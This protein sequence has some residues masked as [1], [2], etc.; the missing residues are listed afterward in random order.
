ME[1][2]KSLIE[3]LAV[4]ADSGL[5]MTPYRGV[6]AVRGLS[7]ID[8]VYLDED[9]RILQLVESYP[10]AHIEP[11]TTPASSVIALPAHSIQTSHSQPGDLLVICVAEEMENRLAQLANPSQ[12]A[13]PPPPPQ[14]TSGVR[15]P[16]S[17]SEG[18]RLTISRSSISRDHTRQLQIAIQKLDQKDQQEKEADKKLSLIQRF[19][20]WLSTDRRRALRHAVPGL[21][22][23]YWTGGAPQ[24]YHIGD[25]SDTGIFLLTEERW[26]PGTMILMTLQRTDTSGNE[27][28]NAIAVQTRV[29][30]WDK[31]GVGLAFVPSKA[32]SSGD[33]S[34]SDNGASKK[35]IERFI[36]K[37]K[38]E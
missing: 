26:F 29:A 13:P 36:K 37:I 31:N 35:T 24:A 6:P 34:F 8:L 3:Q 23:Y 10:T 33:D 15:R 32:S 5:W 21:V 2:L 17:R 4:T 28:G 19:L 12:P 1:K 30:R 20:R 14:Q 7:P 18:P 9:Y 16:I 25:I 22:A 38:S 27:A 11:L